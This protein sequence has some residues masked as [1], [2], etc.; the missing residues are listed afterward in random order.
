MP[1]LKQLAKDRAKL[2]DKIADRKADL[3]DTLTKLAEVEAAI[4]KE[5]TTQQEAK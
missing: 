1:D 4:A 2:L 3:A 5:L